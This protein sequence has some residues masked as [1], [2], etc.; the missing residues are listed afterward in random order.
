MVGFHCYDVA[1]V[2]RYQQNDRL[3]L[4]PTLTDDVGRSVCGECGAPEPADSEKDPYLYHITLGGFQDDEDHQITGDHRKSAL[5]NQPIKSKNVKFSAAIPPRKSS[6]DTSKHIYAKLNR[7]VNNILPGKSGF[8]V[9]PRSASW[10]RLAAPHTRRPPGKS[11]AL[12][13]HLI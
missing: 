8:S 1:G 3:F 12:I 6:G 10:T 13:D 7:N 9:R 5:K 4:E 2:H 11:M